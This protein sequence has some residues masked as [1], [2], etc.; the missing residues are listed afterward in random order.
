MAW[1]EPGV[2]RAMAGYSQRPKSMNERKVMMF[3]DPGQ[4]QGI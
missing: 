4:S 2:K 3:E 1:V